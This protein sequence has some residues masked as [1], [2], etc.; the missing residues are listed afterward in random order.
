MPVPV[1]PT[2]VSR[3]ETIS[4]VTYYET[5]IYIANT[6]NGNRITFDVRVEQQDC[7]L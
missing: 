5:E 7:H 6:G 4:V 3:R 1:S 2:R